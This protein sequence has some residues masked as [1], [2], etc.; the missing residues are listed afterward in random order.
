MHASGMS[1]GELVLSRAVAAAKVQR[2]AALPRVSR[3]AA[4]EKRG[5]FAAKLSRRG[6]AARRSCALRCL[7]SVTEEA[8]SE[9][10]EEP[11]VVAEPKVLIDNL[12][13]PMATI[14]IIE[15]G[16]YL[17][18]LLDTI[19]ALRN[20]GLNVNRAYLSEA[21]NSNSFYVT[22]RRSSEK[23]L[24]SERLDEI[25]TCVLLNM[26]Q[27]H[28]EAK[29]KVGLGQEYGK[30]RTGRGDED[31]NPFAPRKEPEIPTSIKIFAEA[32]GSRSRLDIVTQDRAGVLG[33]I[34]RT[35]KDVSVNVIS[36]EV[37]TV[38]LMAHDV[39]FLTYKG[40]ALSA[41]MEELVKNALY[42]YLTL[43]EVETDESY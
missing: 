8:P 23:I 37:D 6:A 16:D 25:K 19:E 15:F 34:V 11:V 12:S 36:A 35:L 5:P 2:S 13:D 40:T 26:I 3:A 1:R 18:E 10:T 28:P 29:S 9:D 38:G 30:G 43:T 17:G 39:F 32:R 20:L 41:P 33:E 7:A 14:L 22:D 24:L 31:E 4:A 21:K 42:Y 27:Y